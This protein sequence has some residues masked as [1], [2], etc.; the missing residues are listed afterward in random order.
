MPTLLPNLYTAHK[1]CTVASSNAADIHVAV[2]PSRPLIVELDALSAAAKGGGIP[3]VD[4]KMDPEPPAWYW[5]FRFLYA[6]SAYPY[7]G[8]R[9]PEEKLR[10]K[11]RILTESAEKGELSDEVFWNVYAIL[12][13]YLNRATSDGGV[14]GW[15]IDAR[16]RSRSE[17]SW[18]VVRRRNQDGTPVYDLSRAW[19]VVNYFARLHRCAADRVG[20]ETYSPN[21]CS[22]AEYERLFWEGVLTRDCRMAVERRLLLALC[23]ASLGRAVAHLSHWSGRRAD[24]HRLPPYAD[25]QQPAIEM[26]P[27]PK[28]PPQLA[29]RRFRGWLCQA[30]ENW[31]PAN[32]YPIRAQLLHRQG[33]SDLRAS[34]YAPFRYLSDYGEWCFGAYSYFANVLYAA[35]RRGNSGDAEAWRQRE[36]L[37]LMFGALDNQWTVFRDLLWRSGLRDDDPGSDI[38]VLS[39]AVGQL[40]E[41]KREDVYAQLFVP[42]GDAS[43]RHVIDLCDCYRRLVQYLYAISQA[44]DTACWYEAAGSF[45]SQL[46]ELEAVAE[47]FGFARRPLTAV[48]RAEAEMEAIDVHP[49]SAAGGMRGAGVRAHPIN[50]S[51]VQLRQIYALSK[52]RG[53][54]VPAQIEAFH[55]ERS[56]VREDPHVEGVTGANLNDVMLQMFPYVSLK[57]GEAQFERHFHEA[58]RILRSPDRYGAAV[59]LLLE[60]HEELLEVWLFRRN[61]EAVCQLLK[62]LRDIDPQRYEATRSC[63]I[64]GRLAGAL[65]RSY[66]QPAYADATARSSW[67]ETLSQLCADIPLAEW[68][69]HWVQLFITLSA[70]MNL[71]LTAV[72][73]AGTEANQRAGADALHER[74]VR[75][76]SP[77]RP[78]ILGTRHQYP[79]QLLMRTRRPVDTAELMGLL[80]TYSRQTIGTPSALVLIAPL[81]DGMTVRL[82]V[83]GTV[84]G[85]N[86]F[87]HHV[88][89]VVLTPCKSQYDRQPLGSWA[90]LAADATLKGGEEHAVVTEEGTL[91]YNLPWDGYECNFVR[92]V[93]ASVDALARVRNLGYQGQNERSGPTPLV[94]MPGP[95]LASQPW[96]LLLNRYVGC[97]VERA[98]APRYVI[99]LCPSTGWWSASTASYA[100]RIARH[101]PGVF[102]R[103]TDVPL[104]DPCGGDYR[105][106][107]HERFSA[108]QAP[109]FGSL[110]KADEATPLIGASLEVVLAHGTDDP[111]VPVVSR[112]RISADGTP[113][114]DDESDEDDEDRLVPRICLMLAC[115]GANSEPIDYNAISPLTLKLRHS[116]AAV[117]AV[118][119]VPPQAAV[120]MG[121]AFAEEIA[122]PNSRARC[123]DV[124]LR[125]VLDD[126]SG[127]VQLFQL[128]GV[129][130]ALIWRKAAEPT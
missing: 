7:K 21:P 5:V 53:F 96:Q 27:I 56:R 116:K 43:N 66:Q 19:R 73:L 16:K 30:M 3:H 57:P 34:F 59:K 41:K 124:Y 24:E 6:R 97:R 130:E 112:I 31:S 42:R 122:R 118:T 8:I 77:D 100:D 88:E 46:L 13:W 117:G 90:A 79:A 103:I 98:G 81:A 89:D 82:Q 15:N 72:R 32:A 1:R 52:G 108:G 33:A 69:A 102:L 55:D 109:V 11:L 44:C 106:A 121:A 48:S 76:R 51:E 68:R 49:Q 71:G 115:H 80:N 107:L 74:L 47:Q 113:R 23:E 101:T 126:K 14:R 64:C 125:A 20:K 94:L 78:T 120:A 62:V 22:R 40:Y 17:T 39:G 111:S 127:C 95:E 110:V 36:S 25:L 92:L 26:D 9:K 58:A 61:V 129:N 114:P 93:G 104:P 70:L 86:D 18:L 4:A 67:Q 54:L 99:T 119:V 45:A 123:L 75:G 85:L 50:L 87:I 83:F 91:Q 2:S 37:M 12:G 105:A 29:Y 128:W 84:R 38:V 28:E 63:D 60:R 65:L 35:S 10:I